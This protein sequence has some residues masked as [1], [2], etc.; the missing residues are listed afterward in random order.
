MPM[1]G[2]TTLSARNLT[3]RPTQW[4]LL[5]VFMTVVLLLISIN[6]SI[7]LGYFLAFLMIALLLVSLLLAWQNMMQLCLAPVM[8]ERTV[9]AGETALIPLRIENSHR[10]SR[11]SL[12]MQYLGQ[13]SVVEDIDAETTQSFSLPFETSRRGLIEL[14][15]IIIASEYP[16]GLF[17]VSSQLVSAVTLLVYAK[18][19][20]WTHWPFQPA[21]TPHAHESTLFT[22]HHTG[23]EFVGHRAYQ[24]LDPIQWIDWKAS[25]RSDQI[26]VKQHASTQSPTICL[27]WHTLA[28]EPVEQRISKLSY[29]VIAC[30]QQSLAYS[31]KLPNQTVSLNHGSVHQHQCLKALALL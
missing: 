25:S 29:A 5:Y 8:T 22:S 17:R 10:R 9:F 3:V 27:D 12:Q 4:G 15:A 21:N 26:Y 11:F 24:T 16:L 23:D 1:Q 14:P 6:Y 30:H 7:S 20:F 28:H 13:A 31:L 2:Q 18:P 19:S